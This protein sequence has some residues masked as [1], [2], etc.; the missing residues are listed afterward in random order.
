MNACTVHYSWRAALVCCF[1][2]ISCLMNEEF[3]SQIVMQGLVAYLVCVL[4]RRDDDGGAWPFFSCSKSCEGS[5]S[6][7]VTSCKGRRATAILQANANL[8][9]SWC[10]QLITLHHDLCI[11]AAAKVAPRHRQPHIRKYLS[12]SFNFEERWPLISTWNWARTWKLLKTTLLFKT[13]SNFSQS[14]NTECSK[15]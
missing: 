2:W 9:P 6:R 14:L 5:N 10:R 12:I 13:L 7:E 15:T 11:L 3:R 1:L 8:Q 4:L